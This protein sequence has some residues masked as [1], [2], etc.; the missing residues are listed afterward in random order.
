MKPLTGSV[1]TQ[2]GEIFVRCDTNQL[3]F[4][5]GLVRQCHLSGTGIL[6]YMKISDDVATRVP[7]EPR[8]GTLWNLMQIQG[9]E[10]PLNADCCNI[11]DRGR[12]LAEQSDGGFFLR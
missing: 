5:T 12:C 6:Y 2:H 1:D 10:I 7:Y 4:P 9:E 11:D 3:R 8:P